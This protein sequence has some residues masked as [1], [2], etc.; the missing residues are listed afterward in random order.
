MKVL[1]IYPNTMMATLIPINITQL[2]GVLKANNIETALFDTTLYKTE[3]KSFEE[4]RVELL[5]I[6]PFN[7]GKDGVHFVQS[8]IFDDLKNTLET[9]KPDIIATTFV[10][11]TVELGMAL[12]NAVQEYSCLKVVGG[13]YV[14]LYPEEFI[15][16]SLVDVV[17]LGEGEGAIAD[18][19]HCIS[20]GESIDDIKNLWIKKR[21]GNIIKNPMR[22]LVNLDDLPFMDYSIWAPKRLIR[23]MQGKNVSMLHIEMQRGCPY[24]CTYCCAPALKSLYNSSSDQPDSYYRRKSGPRIVEEIEFYLKQVDAV[25]Y[26]NFNAECFLAV[27]LKE[28][29]EFAEMY[30]KRIGLNFWCQTRLETVNDE[31]IAILKEMGCANLQFGIEQGNALFRKEILNRNISN[32]K[33]IKGIKIVEKYKIPY[34]V[35][36]II[37]FPNETRELIF[38]TIELNRHFTP[39]S[40][41]CFILTPYKGTHIQK[42][43]V[44]KGHLNNN[45][46]TRQII[47]GGDLYNPNLTN[48]ELKGLQR[49]FPLYCKFPQERFSEI[50]IA[51]QFSAEGNQMFAKLTE[52]YWSN[53]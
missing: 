46:K 42:I 11:D 41:N 2:A 24:S 47:D 37:G 23:S 49:T 8:N 31:K 45:S 27:P 30:K 21:D 3:D 50:R 20:R 48:E 7:L 28:L 13:V 25:N 43:A 16:N 33:I 34:T 14:S 15:H 26:I 40:V 5:Q 9:F 52:E 22:P 44:E 6:R 17:C 53:Q 12:L 4:K 51:E 29:V 10:E 18:L 1:F 32:E 38:D 36:N 35:N 39:T 19:C